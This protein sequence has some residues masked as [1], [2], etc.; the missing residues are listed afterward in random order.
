[1]NYKISFTKSIVED[2]KKQKLKGT[3]EMGHNG[4]PVFKP[5]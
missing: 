2:A 3:I 5:E 1:M 4:N